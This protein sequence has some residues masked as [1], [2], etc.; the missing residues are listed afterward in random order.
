VRI[1]ASAVVVVG[2]QGLAVVLG[3]AAVE[4]GF[5]FFVGFAFFFVEGAPMGS[6]F[7]AILIIILSI[8]YF[9]YFINISS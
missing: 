4:D 9:T 1:G 7:L 6:V 8:K 3:S 2:V 5:F